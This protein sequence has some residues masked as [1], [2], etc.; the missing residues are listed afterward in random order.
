MSVSSRSNILQNIIN[1]DSVSDLLFN[2]Y[3]EV[4]ARC[5]KLKTVKFSICW[6]SRRTGARTVVWRTCW[7]LFTGIFTS[8]A[9]SKPGAT[10][11]RSVTFMMESRNLGAPPGPVS[12]QC[13][14]RDRVALK[15]L[16]RQLVR[17]PNLEAVRFV[18]CNPTGERLSVQL[19]AH[20]KHWLPMLRQRGL[21]AF[22]SEGWP[23]P[24]S[25]FQILDTFVLDPRYL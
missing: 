7:P 21:L 5:P 16:Q 20:F 22:S 2:A 23:E 14:G 18:N 11:L 3:F 8:I 13:Q 1:H 24:E 9:K 4:L 15:S 12:L 25:Y 6:S 17:L 19:Q 10:A